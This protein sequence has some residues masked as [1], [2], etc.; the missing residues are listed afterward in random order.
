[1]KVVLDTNALL[2]C[3]AKKSDYRLIFDKLIEGTYSIAITNEILN[4]YTE[5]I[6]RKTN[7]RVANN[8]AEFLAEQPNVE[9]IEA[10]FK[11][12]LIG[13]DEEDNKFVD[14]AVIARAKY[15]VTND[16]HFNILKTIPFPK[17]DIVNIDE[18]LEEIQQL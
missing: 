15:I 18:F 4:E 6:E 10:H 12:N 11:W 3:I 16:R 17:V 14:C 7:A 2:M 9:K 5:I 13:A 8:I 1:M